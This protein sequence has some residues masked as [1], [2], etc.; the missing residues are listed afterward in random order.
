M[1]GT[2]RHPAQKTFCGRKVFGCQSPSTPW[3]TL[4]SLRSLTNCKNFMDSDPAHFSLMV[5]LPHPKNMKAFADHHLMFKDGTYIVTVK[6]NT[7]QI[8]SMAHF[9]DQMGS[10]DA[11]ETTWMGELVDWSIGSWFL[12]QETHQVSNPGYPVMGIQPI[13][14]FW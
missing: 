3:I 7:N 6:K 11:L 4:E 1:G 13:M 5:A 2:I 14:S 12:S 8:Q 9:R 10:T